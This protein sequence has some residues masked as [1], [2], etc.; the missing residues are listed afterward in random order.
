MD[1][2][3]VWGGCGAGSITCVE[4]IFTFESNTEDVELGEG[5][6]GGITDENA[7]VDIQGA[8]R[9]AWFPKQFRRAEGLGKACIPFVIPGT[10]ESFRKGSGLPLAFIKPADIQLCIRIFGKAGVRSKG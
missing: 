5:I 3:A 8:L 10:C 2:A 1:M 9:A 6:I 7:A 4:T